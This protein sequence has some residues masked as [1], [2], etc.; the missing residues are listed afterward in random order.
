MLRCGIVDDDEF[1]R[2]LLSGFIDR[3]NGLA[4]AG[5]WADPVEALG[6]NL[7]RTADVLFLDVEMPSLNGL[8]FAEIVGRDVVVVLI[9]GG[10]EYAAKGFDLA[11]AD[12]LLKPFTYSRFLQAV[13][14]ARVRR[15][16]AAGLNGPIFLR[17]N[18]RMISV[19]PADILR[20]EASADYIVVHTS[21][22]K[23]VVHTTMENVARVLRPPD[24]IRIHRSHIVRTDRIVDI[25]L[26]NLV[27][28]QD[29]IPIGA[30]YRPAL[31]TSISW[32]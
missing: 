19:D 8:D 22:G 18:R 9:S 25:E 29:V 2:T 10:A 17:I 32:I 5:S 31:E 26:K 16:D 20:V 14:R 11:V 3:T 12:F 28:G 7:E 1:T 6:A 27:V 13:Q 21:E 4:L 23:H 15:D 30:K 24:F